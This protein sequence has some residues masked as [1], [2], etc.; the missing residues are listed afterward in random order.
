ME[1]SGESRELYA[2]S[3]CK[4]HITFTSLSQKET[5][6]TSQLLYDVDSDTNTW[7]VSGRKSGVV[8]IPQGVMA[9]SDVVLDVIPQTGG[10]LA[11]PGIKLMKYVEKNE[12]S[13][14]P[15]TKEDEG[16][17]VNA[18]ESRS[19][20]QSPLVLPF[21]CGQVYNKTMAVRVC[22][23]PSANPDLAWI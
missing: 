14:E 18:S 13:P 23:L 15:H 10:K 4:W 3:T 16:E 6:D 2:G 7:A 5:P 1:P 19:S 9:T 8:K 20:H 17:E 12:T 22:V 11:M 21:A